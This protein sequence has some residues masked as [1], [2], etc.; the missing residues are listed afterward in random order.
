MHSLLRPALQTNS[1]TVKKD[2]QIYTGI[3]NN[4]CSHLN[5]NPKR[6]YLE[7][8]AK[9]FHLTPAFWIWDHI[10]YMRRQYITSPFIW[11]YF[12]AVDASLPMCSVVTLSAIPIMHYPSSPSAIWSVGLSIF[13]L[14]FFFISVILLLCRLSFLYIVRIQS[15]ISGCR[16]ATQWGY[17]AAGCFSSV[18][19]YN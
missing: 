11:G 7:S 4:P 15:S 9:T 18:L 12:H 8:E 1:I 19:L 17:V 13:F 6:I 5:Y 2:S 3:Y 16:L 14:Q 10:F